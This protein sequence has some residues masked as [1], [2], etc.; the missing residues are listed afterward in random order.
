MHTAVSA[1]SA[2]AV[3]AIFT[4]SVDKQKGFFCDHNM[5]LPLANL[6]HKK[7]RRDVRKTP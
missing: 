4:K 6:I 7:L 5:I 2:T 1:I 3:S